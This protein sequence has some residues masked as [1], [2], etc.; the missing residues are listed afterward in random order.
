MGPG[1]SHQLTLM[2]CLHWS[3]LAVCRYY[4]PFQVKKAAWIAP[5]LGRKAFLHLSCCL[6]G[7]G[8]QSA[9]DATKYSTALTTTDISP[10]QRLMRNKVSVVLRLR[11][12][13]EPG[14][15]PGAHKA[16]NVSA[17][18]LRNGEICCWDY[19]SLGRVISWH[20]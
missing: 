15:M 7:D 16:R 14:N 4:P 9:T 18:F 6:V 3:H 8:R 1:W 13:T 12:L 19:N 5:C 20:A 17:N 2:T 10:Q 11:N